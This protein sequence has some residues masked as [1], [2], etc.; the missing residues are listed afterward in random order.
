MISHL[1]QH[2]RSTY[3]CGIS[4]D[5]LSEKTV[6]LPNPSE[7]YDEHSPVNGGESMDTSMRD[8]EAHRHCGDALCS[9]GSSLQGLD[10]SKVSVHNSKKLEIEMKTPVLD[11]VSV[12]NMLKELHETGQVSAFVSSNSDSG[13]CRVQSMY[14]NKV[15]TNV[16]TSDTC[17]DTSSLIKLELSSV[18]ESDI[19]ITMQDQHQLLVDFG[20]VKDEAV[21]NLFHDSVGK[22]T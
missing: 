7:D 22:G 20:S 1:Q 17:S 3:Q 21:C 5:H 18:D 8:V 10:T 12:E 6:H 19:E 13:Q 14:E 9:I 2:V 11:C 15:E 4:N 16:T